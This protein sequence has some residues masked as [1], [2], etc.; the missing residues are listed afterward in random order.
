MAKRYVPKGPFVYHDV[1]NGNRHPF[2]TD[3]VDPRDGL[4]GYRTLPKGLPAKVRASFRVIEDN[5]PVVE[6]AT[7]SPGEKRTVTRTKP[8]TTKKKA[9]K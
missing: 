6:T 5:E 2:T 7:A 3:Y 4:P 8:K 1:K 9:T